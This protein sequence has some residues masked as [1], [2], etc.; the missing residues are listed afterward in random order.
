MTTQVDDSAGTD[1]APG[2]ARG[3]DR[4]RR[5]AA[6]R[7]WLTALLATGS[8]GLSVAAAG[9]GTLPGD[10]TGARWLQAVSRSVGDPVARFADWVGSH[11]ALVGGAVVVALV[12]AVAGRLPEA[13]LLLATVLLRRLNAVLKDVIESPRPTEEHVRVTEHAGGLGFPSGHAMGVTL[14]YGAVILLAPRLIARRRLRLLVQAAAASVV[15]VTGFGR[16]YTGAHWPSD[17]LGVYLW[18]AVVLVA[19]MWLWRGVI[20][21]ARRRVSRMAQR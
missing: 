12:V 16:V 1:P 21:G 4:P 9:N 11:P 18:G 14:L 15:L 7:A 2:P 20:A 19:L 3:A 5:D 10:V 17:V 13:A 8:L 6:S